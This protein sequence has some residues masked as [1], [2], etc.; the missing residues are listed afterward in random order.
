MGGELFH[1]LLG[2][3]FKGPV[4]PV[5]PA[6]SEIENVRAYASVEAIPGP[7]DLAVI[8]VP[9]AHVIEVAAACARKKV[10]AL[11]VISA[12]FSET[13]N[14]GKAHQAE[15]MNVCRGAGMRLIGPNCMGITNTNPAVLTDI[16]QLRL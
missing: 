13:G 12:G 8:V 3:G 15:L 10:K 2:Y 5:N 4:Y 9:A 6:A 14:A 16:H 11:V 7:V 1:T